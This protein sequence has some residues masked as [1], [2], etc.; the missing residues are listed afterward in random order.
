MPVEVPST[1]LTY[2]SNVSILGSFNENTA[3]GVGFLENF[4][5]SS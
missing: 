1:S 5:M 3:Q 2:H 4:A